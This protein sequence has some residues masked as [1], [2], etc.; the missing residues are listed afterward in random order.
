M[1]ERTGNGQVFSQTKPR[2]QTHFLHAWEVSK[3][4]GNRPNTR[5]F[6]APSHDLNDPDVNLPVD[7]EMVATIKLVGQINPIRVRK[8]P[9][10]EDIELREPVHMPSN[11]VAVCVAGRRRLTAI[12][13]INET[14][15]RWGTPEEIM[16]E[17]KVEGRYST[18][19]D[20]AEVSMVENAARRTVNALSLIEKARAYLKQH[21]EDDEE[22][23]ARCAEL[24]TVTVKKLKQLLAFSTKATPTV[25]KALKKGDVGLVAALELAK[26]SPEKQEEAVASGRL[27]VTKARSAVAES[28]GRSSKP[29]VKEVKE[30]MASL[31][32][33]HPHQD[34]LAWALGLGPKPKL[35]H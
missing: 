34:A 21:G 24:N 6:R 23:L 32:D 31:P 27:S 30:Y 14:E 8:E 26:L 15:Q 28:K 19:K 2:G 11:M 13:Y 1:S 17:V 7:M 12:W 22:V 25:L 10:P 29:T 33:K 3:V 16:V 5:D 18:A 20:A 9:A 35:K 4:G